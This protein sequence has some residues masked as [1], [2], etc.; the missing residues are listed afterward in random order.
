MKVSFFLWMI[1]ISLIEIKYSSVNY[2]KFEINLKKISIREDFLSGRQDNVIWWKVYVTNFS[3]G[4]SLDGMLQNK[5]PCVVWGEFCNIFGYKQR[6]L[7]E[8]A[9][10]YFEIKRCFISILSLVYR[11]SVFC[12]SLY[13][14]LFIHEYIKSYC[15]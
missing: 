5:F 12:F 7:F 8:P 2:L 6:A 9:M 13:K 4:W 15:L 14:L 11:F 3:I 1:C 10:C